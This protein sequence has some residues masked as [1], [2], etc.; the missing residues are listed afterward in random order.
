MFCAIKDESFSRHFSILI[1]YEFAHS[2]AIFIDFFMLFGSFRKIRNQ[3]EMNETFA[4]GRLIHEASLQIICFV[5]F[6]FFFHEYGYSTAIFTAFHNGHQV[7]KWEPWRHAYSD[8]PQNPLS[9]LYL[10]RMQFHCQMSQTNNNV[11]KQ[12]S[13]S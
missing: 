8:R 5:Y 7:G 13:N 10:L 12:L 4:H 9:E 6:S 11:T 2:S 1:C 3:V